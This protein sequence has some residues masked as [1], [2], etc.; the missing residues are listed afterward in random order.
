MSSR[1][2]FVIHGVTQASRP[3]RSKVIAL[4]VQDMLN[5]DDYL[6]GS[7]TLKALPSLLGALK[8]VCTEGEWAKALEE[9]SHE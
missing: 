9:A 2:Y 6:S 7:I 5:R 4:L 8:A 1:S 3:M